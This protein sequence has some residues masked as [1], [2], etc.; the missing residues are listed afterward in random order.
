MGAG[1]AEP[2]SLDR[3]AVAGGDS[4]PPWGAA[5]VLAASGVF[6][7]ATVWCSARNAHF[8]CLPLTRS[9]RKCVGEVTCRCGDPG[10][11]AEPSVPPP[12]P[13]TSQCLLGDSR[14]AGGTRDQD[15]DIAG[16]EQGRAGVTLLPL[17]RAGSPA[18]PSSLPRPPAKLRA[19]PEAGTLGR[20]SGG[21]RHGPRSGSGHPLDRAGRGLG[22][23]F[24][25]R[26]AGRCPLRA[27]PALGLPRA[28]W[29]PRTRSLRAWGARPAGSGS[30]R[31]TSLPFT[32]RPAAPARGAVVTDAPGPSRGAL[33]PF[34]DVGAGLG[35]GTSSGG[36]CQP[37]KNVPEVAAG[38]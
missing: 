13:Q 32:P 9:R 21:P 10:R 24:G 26:A 35:Y 7:D 4:R 38:E 17:P 14:A 20:S 12:R 29:R 27:T 18:P 31:P 6:S 11:R 34:S 1:S 5:A 16:G 3:E 8:A 22:G 28:S 23:H 2:A 30:P 37:W 15:R 36:K 33:G 25:G 19:V